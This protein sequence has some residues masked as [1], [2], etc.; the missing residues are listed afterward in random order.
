VQSRD[1]RDRLRASQ[2]KGPPKQAARTS[3]CGE[4]DVIAMGGDQP[5]FV[6][7]ASSVPRAA[8]AKIATQLAAAA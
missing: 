3:Y 1:R 5:T 7:G 6:T 4:K 8:A 2:K